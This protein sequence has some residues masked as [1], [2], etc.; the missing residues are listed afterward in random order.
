MN[1]VN[2]KALSELLGHKDIAMTAR[3]SHLSVS[4][5]RETVAKLPKLNTGG[6]AE[7]VAEAAPAK[8]VN[9]AN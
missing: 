7:K 1:N 2:T 4:Y 3:Y 8:I 6:S 9:F 5:K